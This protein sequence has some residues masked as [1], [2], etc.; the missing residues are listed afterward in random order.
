MCIDSTTDSIFFSYLLFLFRNLTFS[1]GDLVLLSIDC[2]CTIMIRF[3]E[4]D[5]GIT[6]K[7]RKN[8]TYILPKRN[9]ASYY[10]TILLYHTM[11]YFHNGILVKYTLD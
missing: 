3:E 5:R 10:Y 4:N 1:K 7:E 9:A 8:K 11:L 6:E 2:A